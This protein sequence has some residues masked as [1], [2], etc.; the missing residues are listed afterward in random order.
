MRSCRR[1]N[2]FVRYNVCNATMVRE[3]I[4]TQLT[5]HSH[6]PTTRQSSTQPSTQPSAQPPARASTRPHVR[7]CSRVQ[8]TVSFPRHSQPATSAFSKRRRQLDVVWA[9]VCS[10]IICAG[11]S[12]DSQVVSVVQNASATKI[13][14][15]LFCAP[16]HSNVWNHL[17]AVDKRLLSENVMSYIG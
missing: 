8:H 6:S 5:K 12:L 9:T 4:L 16:L 14:A 7:V 17:E 2:L 3:T 11:E 10:S 15:S 13:L 1:M